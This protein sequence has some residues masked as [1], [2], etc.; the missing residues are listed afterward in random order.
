MCINVGKMVTNASDKF[1]G[2]LHYFRLQMPLFGVTL[3]DFPW[4][5]MG[6]IVFVKCL[7]CNHACLSAYTYGHGVLE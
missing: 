6:S 3:Q 4:H 7:Q 5:M 2:I 1:R